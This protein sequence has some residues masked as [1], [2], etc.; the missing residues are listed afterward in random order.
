MDLYQAHDITIRKEDQAKADKILEQHDIDEITCSEGNDGGCRTVTYWIRPY[1]S[2]DID[3]IVK[4]F[5]DNGI[6]VL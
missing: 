3:D 6:Q 2:E 4:D 1:L 5:R